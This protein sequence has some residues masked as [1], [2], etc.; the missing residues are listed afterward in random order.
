[1]A[2]EIEC[3]QRVLEVGTEQLLDLGGPS[4]AE[5]GVEPLECLEVASPGRAGKLPAGQLAHHPVDLFC[6][7]LPRRAAGERQEAAQRPRSSA[8]RVGTE[9]TGSLGAEVCLD[10]LLLVNESI[11]HRLRRCR[12]P[13]THDPQPGPIHAHVL[14]A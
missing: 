8:D 11:R 14:L 1:M 9:T 6:P 10:A 4:C 5:E 2:T 12:G 13:L 3:I 7:Q